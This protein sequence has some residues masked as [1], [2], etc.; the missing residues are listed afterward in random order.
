VTV[1]EEGSHEDQLSRLEQWAR[2]ARPEGFL[3]LR[4]PGFALAGFQYLR[5]LFGANTTK[6]DIHIIRLVGSQVGH[7]VS[8]IQALRMLEDAASEAGIS[9]RDLDTT[10]WESSARSGRPDARQAR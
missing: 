3:A 10:I 4:I 7:P 9:L 5:M 2:T 8:P 1:S 6:P